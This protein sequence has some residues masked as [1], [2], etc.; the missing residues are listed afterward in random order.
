M[1]GISLYTL[2]M[3][4]KT[5]ATASQSWRPWGQ[6]DASLV[7]SPGTRL[8]A[9]T[10]PSHAASEMP[11]S[12]HAGLSSRTKRPTVSSAHRGMERGT[13]GKM[14]M[15]RRIR[16]KQEGGDGGRKCRTKQEER[17]KSA[18][19]RPPGRTGST[20]RSISRWVGE[21]AAAHVHSRIYTGYKGTKRGPLYRRVQRQRRQV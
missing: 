8:H 13:Q 10:S 17:T 14:D 9:L 12:P 20:Y 4:V 3:D 21:E 18:T 15:R 2:P 7:W 5:V 11:R 6:R 1:S 16:Q 19:A